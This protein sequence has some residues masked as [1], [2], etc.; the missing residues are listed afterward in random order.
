MQS[1]WSVMNLY[2]VCSL[3]H[4]KKLY[5]GR[6]ISVPGKG[7]EAEQGE[8]LF[9]SPY[10]PGAQPRLI[11]H[12]WTYLPQDWVLFFCDM[13]WSPEWLFSLDLNTGHESEWRKSMIN[14]MDF[15]LNQA[16]RCT[17]FSASLFGDVLWSLDLCPREKPH[18]R[19]ELR[20]PCPCGDLSCA[21]QLPVWSTGL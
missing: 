6:L 8:W 12:S 5:K 9:C 18:S 10:K 4:H 14:C 15:S 21:A 20:V 16:M 13:T 17:N 3:M 1:R 19:C 7:G 2:G 11:R